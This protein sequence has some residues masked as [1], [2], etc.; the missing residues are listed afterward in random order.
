LGLVHSLAASA[1]AIE[2][3]IIS[4]LWEGLLLPQHYPKTQMCSSLI[5]SV[6]S[7]FFFILKISKFNCTVALSDQNTENCQWQQLQWTVVFHQ[8]NAKSEELPNRHIFYISN[9][10]TFFLKKQNRVIIICTLF[11]LC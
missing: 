7:I 3:E 5:H 11:T 10:T 6:M 1:E 4:A 2:T 8:N 9:M